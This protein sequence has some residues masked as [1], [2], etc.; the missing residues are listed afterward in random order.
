MRF[1]HISTREMNVVERVDSVQRSAIVRSRPPPSLSLEKHIHMNALSSLPSL[2]LCLCLKCVG[3]SSPLICGAVRTCLNSHLLS[4]VWHA[5]QEEVLITVKKHLD[6][7]TFA[8][9]MLCKI[10]RTCD[11]DHFQVLLY[12]HLLVLL[13]DL[14]RWRKVGRPA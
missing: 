5:C 11:V 8:S 13:Q 9:S 4:S 1:T 3:L 14:D 10:A 6:T 2:S 12:V 7:S